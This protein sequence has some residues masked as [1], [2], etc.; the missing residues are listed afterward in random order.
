M[1]SVRDKIIL[2]FKGF[3]ITYWWIFGCF[4][5]VPKFFCIIFIELR[6][7]H[8][9][10]QFLSNQRS[11]AFLTLLTFKVDLFPFKAISFFTIFR[12]TFWQGWHFPILIL[13]DPLR[14]VRFVFSNLI[15]Y[16]FMHESWNG[17]VQQ[18]IRNRVSNFQTDF[19]GMFRN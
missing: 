7:I 10:N 3:Q 13:W 6:V 11:P 14:F 5:F 15:T 8:C 9:S 1:N 17:S 2:Y 4:T 12:I 18:N 19:E 16:Q